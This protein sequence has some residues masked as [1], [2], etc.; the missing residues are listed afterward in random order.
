MANS[1]KQICI[2]YKK[3]HYNNRIRLNGIGNLNAKV[4]VDFMKIQHNL[5]IVQGTVS[6]YEIAS[7]KKRFRGN[8]L[9]R[10][11]NYKMKK[12]QR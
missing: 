10:R 12:K 9:Q 1:L 5:R 7:W 11:K 2:Y 4:N 3:L 8:N 6:F